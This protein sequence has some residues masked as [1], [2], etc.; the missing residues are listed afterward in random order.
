[1]PTTRKPQ[2]QSVAAVP[3]IMMTAA[4]PS[5][6]NDVVVYL[7]ECGGYRRIAAADNIGSAA[8]PNAAAA[9]SMKRFMTE[10]RPIAVEN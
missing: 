2:V 4:T 5:N 10:L 6:D 7:R 9:I 1:M 3:P 8:K